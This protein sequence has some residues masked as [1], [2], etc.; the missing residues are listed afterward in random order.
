METKEDLIVKV[1]KKK[2]RDFKFKDWIET[3]LILLIVL[4]LSVQTLSASN[5]SLNPPGRDG[6]FFLY[7]GK[8]IKTGARLYADIWDSK[9][10]LIFWINALGVGT[11]YSRWG[12]FLIELTFWAAALLIAYSIIK[13]RYGKLPAIGSIFIGSYLLKLVIGQGNFTEEYSLLFTWVNL[14][15]LVLLTANDKKVFWPFFL[16]GVT[17]VFNFLLRANNIGTQVVVILVALINVFSRQNGTKLW[18]ALISLIIGALTVGIPTTLYFL[19]NGTFSAMID[20]SILYNFAYST[21]RGNPFSNGLIPAMNAFKGWFFCFLFLWV[22]AA[23]QLLFRLKQKESVPLLLVTVCALPI[24][25]FMS[26]I[27]GRGYGHYF[28]CWIPAYMLLTAFGLYTA[29]IEVINDNFRKKIESVHF[30]FFLVLLILVS[31]VGSIK[32]FYNTAKFI[33]ASIIRPNISREYRDPVSKVVNGLTSDSDKVLVFAGQAGINVMAQRDSINGALFYPAINNSTIG[34]AVQKDFFEN[35]QEEMPQLILDGHSIYP[36]QIPAIDPLT[37]QNQRF[38]VSFSDNL[39][40]VMDW[41]NQ[42][43]EKYDEANGYVI[44]R[45]RNNS[46]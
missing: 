7:I 32:T 45:L 36:E 16:M 23:Y 33:A 6:G 15:A 27:S 37:R 22:L 41:I 29:Q 2:L 4:L 8:S 35:L 10:P 9:G 40:E 1:N 24:E 42:H 5:P 31:F 39:E 18:R 25:V 13:I 46:Q 43:Y 38:V 30:S 26:S 3:G 17:I 14:A 11:D 34:L 44:Y 28:I 21:A 20:A 19:A 12:V